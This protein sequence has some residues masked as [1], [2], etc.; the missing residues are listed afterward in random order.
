MALVGG[1]QLVVVVDDGRRGGAGCHIWINGMDVSRYVSR[2]EI[3]RDCNDVPHAGRMCV[4]VTHEKNSSTCAFT[5]S[6]MQMVYPCCKR[7]R[8][9]QGLYAPLRLEARPSGLR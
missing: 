5:K 7:H 4:L 8:I 1:N 6:G 2:Y 9:R 3:E